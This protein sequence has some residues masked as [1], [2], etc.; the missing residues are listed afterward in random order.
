[1]EKG[2]GERSPF[3]MT[4]LIRYRSVKD[5]RNW[6]QVRG[7]RVSRGQF[8]SSSVVR[9]SQMLFSQVPAAVYPHGQ[10]SRHWLWHQ[11]P[12]SRYCR[13]VPGLPEGRSGCSRPAE[14]STLF[15]NFSG[16]FVSRFGLSYI[17]QAVIN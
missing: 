1:M 3:P 2:F 8:S 13:A 17:L 15:S 14:T 11:R 5:R 12:W 10:G 4:H 16:N 7:T 9:Q 6:L